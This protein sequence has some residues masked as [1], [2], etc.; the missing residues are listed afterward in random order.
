MA[1]VDEPSV[2]HTACAVVPIRAVK[3]LVADPDDVLVTSVTDGI[4][5]LVAA[6]GEL[7]ADFGFQG[8]AFG[9]RDERVLGVVSMLVFGHALRAEIEVGTGSAVEELVFG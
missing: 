2:H 8:E 7:A 6:R 9:N 3:A 5:P 4:V 1:R